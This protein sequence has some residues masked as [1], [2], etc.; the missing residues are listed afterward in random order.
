M[1]DE[2]PQ[3]PASDEVPVLSVR[4]LAFGH[5][6]ERTWE[7]VDFE[8]YAGEVALLVG[9]NGA[10]KTTLLKCLAGWMN[11][12]AG[13]VWVDGVLSLLGAEAAAL[14]L[15]VACAVFL[16]MIASSR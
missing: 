7:H 14:G 5:G 8:L 6:A 2:L 1:A 4:D 3:A 13:E 9:P 16:S 12:R 10:G 11:P 15:L